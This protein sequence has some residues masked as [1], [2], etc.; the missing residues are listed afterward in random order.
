MNEIATIRGR[1]MPINFDGEPHSNVEIPSRKTETARA[2]E[3][4]DRG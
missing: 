4:V 3:K 2:S 1:G